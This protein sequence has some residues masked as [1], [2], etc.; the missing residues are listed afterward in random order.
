[1][2]MLKC[3][4]G[5]FLGHTSSFFGFDVDNIWGAPHLMLG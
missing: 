4:E 5:F 2:S 1:M 3:V